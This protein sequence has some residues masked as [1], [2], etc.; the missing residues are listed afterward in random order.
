MTQDARFATTMILHFGYGSVIGALYIPFARLAPGLRPLN[1]MVF[2]L[3][4]WAGSY[5]GWL[6]MTGLISPATRHPADRN[7]LMIAAHL[8]W[9]QVI[10][11]TS[12]GLLRTRRR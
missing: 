9:G 1:G 11:L 7:R 5:L 6:P 4:V 3:L 8:A 2:G 12:Q 10:A